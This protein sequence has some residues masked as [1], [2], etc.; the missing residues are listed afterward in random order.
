MESAALGKGV[1]G[2]ATAEASSTDERLLN[3]DE[4]HFGEEV[5]GKGG[6]EDWLATHLDGESWG[7]YRGTWLLCLTPF[8]AM[9]RPIVDGTCR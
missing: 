6:E 2:K 7:E 1:E 3:F 9:P 8:L 4:G 5:K